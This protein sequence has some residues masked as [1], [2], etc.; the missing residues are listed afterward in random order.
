VLDVAIGWL[1]SQPHVPSVIA[2][3]TRPEQVEQNVA[4]AGWRLTP[5][6]LAEVDTATRREGA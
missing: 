4:A 5:E 3:A 2:G 6:E 1:A